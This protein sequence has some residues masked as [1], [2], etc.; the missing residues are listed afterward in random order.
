MAKRIPLRLGVAC[1]SFAQASSRAAAALVRDRAPE[2]LLE[3]LNANEQKLR[4]H[5]MPN[6]RSD[7]KGS[8][9]KIKAHLQNA[10]VALGN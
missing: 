7:P 6:F 9:M 3:A 5:N 4:R 2:P 8:G 1:S 10:I